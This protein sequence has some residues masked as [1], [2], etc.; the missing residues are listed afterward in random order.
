MLN[1]II[2]NK[3]L[4]EKKMQPIITPE[5]IF[6]LISYHMIIKFVKICDIYKVTTQSV[7]N[8]SMAFS[9]ECVDWPI[10]AT[11]FKDFLFSIPLVAELDPDSGTLIH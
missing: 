2:Q 3:S 5:V 9:T 4:T 1:Y 7:R 6:K 11:D 10:T 8:S